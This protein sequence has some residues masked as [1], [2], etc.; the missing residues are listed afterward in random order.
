MGKQEK[1]KTEQEES[2]VGKTEVKLPTRGRMQV[3]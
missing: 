2:H 3:E 1:G